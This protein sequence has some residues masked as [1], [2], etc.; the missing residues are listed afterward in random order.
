MGDANIAAAAGGRFYAVSDWREGGLALG[1]A[2]PSDRNIAK[3]F[4]IL[5]ETL[6]E[7]K[8]K[9]ICSAAA[10][11][12][13]LYTEGDGAEIFTR[14]A[15]RLDEMQSEEYLSAPHNPAAPKVL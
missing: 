12:D 15:S 14:I 6:Y 5:I 8:T 7:Q 2:R 10:A 9:L 3:R 1:A 11:P 4:S 13:N